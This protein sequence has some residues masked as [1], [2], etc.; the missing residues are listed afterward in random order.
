MHKFLII[1]TFVHT[2]LFSQIVATNWQQLALKGKVMQVETTYINNSYSKT[3]HNKTIGTVL[4]S[5]PIFDAPENWYFNK[6]GFLKYKLIKQS[7]SNSHNIKESF[8]YYQDTNLIKIV[9]YQKNQKAKWSISDSVIIS[10]NQDTIIYKNY[11]VLCKSIDSIIYIVKNNKLMAEFA[12]YPDGNN[13]ITY[14]YDDNKQL[15]KEIYHYPNGKKN[16]WNTQN[17]YNEN[18]KLISKNQQQGEGFKVVKYEYYPENGLI[19]SESFNNQLLLY[20]YKFDSIGNWILKEI[21]LN[22]IIIYTE[23]RTIKYYGNK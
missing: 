1:F 7:E 22:N 21:T 19:K 11:R 12:T 9:K 13:K 17:V 4:D 10:N 2:T 16:I 3:N 8:F 18:K 6:N 5:M 20:N 15:M 23:K 14:E